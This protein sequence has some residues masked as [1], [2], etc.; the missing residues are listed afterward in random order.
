MLIAD[1]GEAMEKPVFTGAGDK[2][3]RHKVLGSADR[4][5]LLLQFVLL[6]VEAECQLQQK[7]EGQEAPESEWPWRR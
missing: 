1:I 3:G 7:E 6:A 5:P 2:A 4:K